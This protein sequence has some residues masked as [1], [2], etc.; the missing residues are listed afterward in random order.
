MTSLRVR[1]VTLREANALV[2]SLHRHHPP[3]RGHKFSIGVENAVGKLCGA[4]II[5]RPKARGLDRERGGVRFTAEVTRLVT[6]GE[7]N[8]CSA[9]YSAAARAAEAMGY[10]LIVTYIRDDEPGTSLVAAGWVSSGIVTARSWDCP[11]RRRKD[12]TERVPR[13]RYEKHLHSGRRR[14]R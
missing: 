11:S 7:P 8:A 3:D 13:V 5:G 6:D 12:T 10:D 2:M 14:K 9:L 4:V 1:P